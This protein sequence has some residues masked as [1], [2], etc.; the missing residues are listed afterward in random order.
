MPL[1]DTNLLITSESTNKNVLVDLKWDLRFINISGLIS[2]SSQGFTL[3]EILIVMGIMTVI[4]GW[5]LFLSFD[6]YKSYAFAAEKEAMSVILQKARNQAMSNIN[7]KPHGVH[8]A[9]NGKYIIFEGLVYDAHDPSNFSID[10]SYAVSILAPS[11]PFDVVFEPLSGNCISPACVNGA[12]VIAMRSGS[13]SDSIIIN[14]E[15]GIQYG[16]Q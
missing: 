6:F 15:G 4:L 3:L 12:L 13:S 14:S 2:N 16:N 8:V 9:D 1:S 10:A 11:L 7:Q 5:G